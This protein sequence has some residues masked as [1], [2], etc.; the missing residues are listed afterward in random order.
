MTVDNGVRCSTAR[1]YLDPVRGRPNLTIR[2]HA[3]AE[4]LC[5][6]DQRATGVTYLHRGGSVT[7]NARREVL[8]CAGAIASP[9][10]LLL[11]GIG[12]PKQLQPH[13]I[14][15][16]HELPG[17]GRNL[18]DHLEIYF[19]QACT[20]PVS[21]NRWL[22]LAGKGLIDIVPSQTP[23]EVVAAEADTLPFYQIFVHD[24]LVPIVTI[25]EDGDRQK[26]RARPI[27]A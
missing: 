8:L 20:Q 21:L 27:P 14:A 26:L 11:S 3:A 2:T 13:E 15:T 6:R 5:L 25:E 19:Q 9:Q 7:V 17:V 1:A 12:D 18:M 16:T 24:G 10:L 22:S 23:A 4:R